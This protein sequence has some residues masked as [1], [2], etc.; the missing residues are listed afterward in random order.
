MRKNAAMVGGVTTVQPSAR[1]L[2]P[3]AVVALA[4]AALAV[5]I[6][7][8][9]W[10]GNRGTILVQRITISVTTSGH[11][12]NHRPSRFSVTAIL[13]TSAGGRAERSFT[14]SSLDRRG[15]QQA[16][17]GHTMQLYDPRDNTIY[18]ATEPA[19]QRALAAQLRAS[20]PKGSTVS[21][22]VGRTQVV[23]AGSVGYMPAP[24]G[25]YARWLG[26][27][28]YRP[29]GRTMIDGRAALRFV[30]RAPKRPLGSPAATFGSMTEVL[31]APGSYDPI[32]TITTTR[33]PGARVTSITRW[34]SYRALNDTPANRWLV[35]LTER[36]PSARLVHDAMAFL[37]AS[38]LA[39]RR[40]TTAAAG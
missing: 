5:L 8:V 3:M 27:G 9:L 6:S 31:V 30:A 37:R 39:G 20:S 40:Q 32:E 14:T 21:V 1:A 34:D 24:A 22:G 2:A 17:A 29:L 33:L 13:E 15:F 38:Q 18:E 36:H 11:G 23:S 25:R 7:G 26:S 19:L 16:I 12:V 35:S 10:R 4:V 28:Q